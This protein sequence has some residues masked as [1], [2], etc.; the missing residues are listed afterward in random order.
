MQEIAIGLSNKHSTSLAIRERKIK[1]TWKEHFNFI[2]AEKK[3]M[4]NFW[5]SSKEIEILL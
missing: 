5:S 3:Y 4:V 1:L 2:L